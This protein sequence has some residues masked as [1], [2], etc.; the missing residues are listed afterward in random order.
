MGSPPLLTPAVRRHT[1]AADKFFIEHPSQDGEESMSG[2]QETAPGS[3]P[4]LRL[5]ERCWRLISLRSACLTIRH[6]DPDHGQLVLRSFRHLDDDPACTGTQLMS[7]AALS[8]EHGEV[9]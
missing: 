4:G 6:S 7:P 9:A 5:C 8:D 2:Y 3:S 1:S